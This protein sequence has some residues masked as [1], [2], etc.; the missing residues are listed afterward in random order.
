VSSARPSDDCCNVSARLSAQLKSPRLN[1]PGTISDCN[2]S[3]VPGLCSASSVSDR[4]RML[5]EVVMA[6]ISICGGLRKHLHGDQAGVFFSAEVGETCARLRFQ[7]GANRLMRLASL[8]VDSF[9]R[10]AALQPEIEHADRGATAVLPYVSRHPP[11]SDSRH[12]GTSIVVRWQPLPGLSTSSRPLSLAPAAA[13]R[14]R[15]SVLSCSHR[16]SLIPTGIFSKSCSRIHSR[17]EWA[18][19]RHS[20][21]KRVVRGFFFV[22]RPA[23]PVP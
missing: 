12:V 4:T 2:L 15:S 20:L 16:I 21:I 14:R 23:F 13:T 18:L 7:K 6:S 8:F 10:S 5:G 19:L 22:G 17:R 11:T 3:S 9:E 1:L